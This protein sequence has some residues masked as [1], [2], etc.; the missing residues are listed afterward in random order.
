[1]Q[2]Y[3]IT[4][5]QTGV[6]REGVNFLQPS[7]SFEEIVDGF[8]ERQVLKSRKGFKRFSI[9]SLT[10]AIADKTRVMGIFEHT[11]GYRSTE[12]LAITKKALYKYNIGTD[13]F[14]QIPMAGAAPA[15][16]FAIVSDD[17][18]VSGTTYPTKTGGNRFVFTGKGMTAVYFYDGTDVK[19]FTN[20]ADNTDYE[21][22]AG[23]ALTKAHHVMWFGER[24]NL[25]NPTIGGTE[26]PQGILYSAIRN[27]AGNGDKFNTSGSGLLNADTAE[28]I[29]G[30][31]I[32]GDVIA[33]NFTRS[34]WTLEKTRDNFNPYFIRKISSELGS[35]APFSQVNRDGENICIGKTGIIGSNG[36]NSYRVDN[37]IPNYIEDEFDSANI[38]YTY[39]GFDRFTEQFLFS[40]TSNSAENAIQDKVLVNNYRENSWSVF[41]QRFSCFGQT[42]KG[43][44]DVW[45]VIEDDGNHP[46]WARWDTTEE[47][48]NKIGLTETVQKT[49]AGDDN[50]FIYH[51][52][53]DNEDY[54][55][56]ISD[57][58]IANPAVLTIG[59]HSFEIGDEVVVEN[60]EGMQNDQGITTINNYDPS[61]S[62]VN[63]IS[64]TITAV[65]ATTVT[66]N[67]GSTRDSAYTASTGTISKIISFR[68]KTIPFN[69]FRSEGRKCYISHVE[70]LLATNNGHL[71]VD[72][73]EDEEGTPIRKDILI[74][75]TSIYKRKEWV[76]LSINQESNF[77]NLILKQESPEVQ[78]IVYSIRIHC[79]PGGLTSG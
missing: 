38:T 64:W 57:I 16:G 67:Y 19:V 15:A 36:R 3:E 1:M 46:S 71:K 52:N 23:G 2:V 35:N 76:T 9:G 31:S 20:A 78:A 77:I 25:F 30:A 14:D 44:T 26:N 68:A 24:L 47:I 18:Y 43:Q 33:I 41:N 69:P 66:I 8:L 53:Q 5:F 10:G 61:D 65:A 17:S 40:F 6:S 42:D 63:F 12:L 74:K 50:G 55:N 7:D 39:G 73:L 59:D 34:N 49:L 48:W 11:V 22:F 60:V 79:Q 29:N 37:K 51:I 75:P 4:G 21:A 54:I 56:A 70:F 32:S 45:N 27:T 13:T 72:V 62:Q 28:Y 58:T